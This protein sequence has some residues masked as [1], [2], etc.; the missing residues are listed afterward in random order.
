MKR[1]RIAAATALALAAL[2]AVAGC[3]GGPSAPSPDS[4][5]DTAI[6]TGECRLLAGFLSADLELDPGNVEDMLSILASLI[7]VG[8]P[9]SAKVAEMIIA[10]YSDTP[11]SQEEADAIVA[12]W[13]AF[14]TRNAAG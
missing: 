13:S 12:E 14:C 9:E 10:S 4:G 11:P 1:P 3:S 8:Y 7:D 2:L 6:A 5:V